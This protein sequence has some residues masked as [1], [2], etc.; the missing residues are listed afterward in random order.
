MKNL[1]VKFTIA[2]TTQNFINVFLAL[3][4]GFDIIYAQKLQ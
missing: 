3:L 1:K 4:Q 2:H